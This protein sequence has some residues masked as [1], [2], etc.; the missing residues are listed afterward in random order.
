M[1]IVKREDKNKNIIEFRPYDKKYRYIVNGEV[2]K[3]VTTLIGARFG[4]NGLIG[5]A[6][7]LPLTALEYQLTEDGKSKDFIQ[8]FVD[9]LK[10]KVEE[11]SIK[12][13]TTGTLMHSYCE[14]YI[15]KKKIVAPT[16]EPLITMYKKFTKWWDSKN[17]KVLATEQ[18]CYSKDLDVCGTFDVIVKD[19]KD[20]VILLDFKT[21]KAF[22]PDQPI[23]IATYKKLIEDSNNIKIDCY[24]IINIPKESIKEVSLVM[25][26]PKPRYLKAFKVCKFLDSYEQ[27]FLKRQRQYNKITKGK[28]YVSKK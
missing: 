22:Y 6:K 23:Q 8:S 25:Y 20:K 1:T 13:A 11:L 27:D 26:D 12:D 9:R 7:K 17:Y 14:D 21:S 2:K 4:K 16:T 24:G 15:N 10:K 5:W 18:T 3:G 28:K 19:K